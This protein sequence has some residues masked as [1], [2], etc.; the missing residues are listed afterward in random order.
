MKGPAARITIFDAEE[1][2][3]AFLPRLDEPITESLV[4]LDPVEVIRYTGRNPG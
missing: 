1:R 4:I 2:V 3:H